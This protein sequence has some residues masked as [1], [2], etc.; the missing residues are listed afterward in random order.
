MHGI[1]FFVLSESIF[2]SKGSICGQLSSGIDNLDFTL[3]FFN[4]ICCYVI[5]NLCYI[6]AH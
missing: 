2:Q 6:L 3:M 5:L 1:Q 4:M